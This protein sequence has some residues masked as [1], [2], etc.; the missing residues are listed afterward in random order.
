M[1][2]LENGLTIVNMVVRP[3]DSGSYYGVIKLMAICDQGHCGICSGMSLAAGNDSGT[4]A[5]GQEE[6][7]M[8]N[9]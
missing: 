8:M 7:E 9:F 1:S 2:D 3:V 4:L 5:L 6:Q